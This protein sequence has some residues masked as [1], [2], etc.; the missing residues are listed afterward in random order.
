MEGPV[1]QGRK[2]Q[3]R[4]PPAAGTVAET[5]ESDLRADAAGYAELGWPNDRLVTIRKVE[6]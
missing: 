3:L 4:S 5:P 2:G 1:L 6:R